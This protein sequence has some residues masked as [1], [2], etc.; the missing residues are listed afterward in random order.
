MQR[1]PN[2]NTLICSA[3]QGTIFEVTPAGK[4]VW[5]YVN[6]ATSSRGRLRQGDP[7]PIDPG[8]EARWQSGREVWRNRVYRAHRYPPDHP[9]LRALDLTPGETV[10][11]PAAAP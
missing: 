9:G 8:A 6:P 1:L 4:T 11:L 2:G 7:M 5:K 3:Q 10:E